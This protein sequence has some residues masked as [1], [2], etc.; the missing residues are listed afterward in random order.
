M[1]NTDLKHALIVGGGFSGMAA[2]IELRKRGIAVD[3]VEIDSGWRSY[4]AGITIGGATLRALGTIGV[5]DSVML[6]GFCADGLDILTA[7][8]HHIAELPT[9]RVAGPNVPGG[10]AIMRPTL[11]KILAE[12]TIAAGVDV[13]LGCTVT[14]VSEDAEH[15]EV[16]F[17]DGEKRRYDVVIGADGLYSNMRDMLFPAAP[18]PKYTGQGVWRAV[19]P[20]PAEIKRPMMWLGHG[21][22]T[23]VNPVSQDEMYLFV[24]EDRPTH[25]RIEDSQLLGLLSGLLERFPAEEM[26]WV[27]AKLDGHSQ[28]VYRPLES[29]L[30]PQPWHRGRVVLIGDAVHATTPHLAA[31]AGIGIEDAIVLGEELAQAATLADGLAGFERRRWERCRMVVENSGRLGELEITGGDKAEHSRII[32]DSITALAQPI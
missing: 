5:L 7:D 4:G 29:L 10:G 21:V 9:P 6:E 12:A 24:T 23:G 22:K 1:N 26:Q 18:T 2:A 31:G 13:R 27:R 25:T 8:G 16:L 17:T 20:R 14:A 19:L 11:A 28:I 32:R 3:L 15:A 30:V